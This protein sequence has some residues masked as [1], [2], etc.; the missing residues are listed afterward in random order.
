MNSKKGHFIVIE[1]LEG[2]GKSTALDRIKTKLMSHGLE[3]LVT[4]EP[5]GTLLGEAVR[6]LIKNTIPNEPLDA[7]AELLLFYAARVQLVEQVIKPALARGQ[8]VLADRFELS[9]FAY[10]GAGRGLDRSMIT[11]L[12]KFCLHGFQ[13]DLT[14]FL[15]IA[16]EQGF[17]RI[18]ARGHLDRI[19]Q[20][21]L[22][23]FKAVH[24]SY[25]EQIR[26]MSHVVTVDASQPLIEVSASI[27]SALE[28]YL[29]HAI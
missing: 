14:F 7:R 26:E 16:P 6:G 25:H 8:W 19:E 15:D 21:S 11:Q 12:S 1:G 9:T 20:E 23:F 27:Q 29:H 3:V 10:Q 4:R 5:G 2:A 13:P 18:R 24:V 17:Q 28:A 22:D